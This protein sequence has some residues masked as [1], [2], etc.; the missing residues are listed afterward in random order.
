MGD[1]LKSSTRWLIGKFRYNPP[2]LKIAL[3]QINPTSGD[4]EGNLAL[5]EEVLGRAEQGGADLLILPELAP[6]SFPP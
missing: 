2:A 1:S 4:F 6:R 5:I 3:G